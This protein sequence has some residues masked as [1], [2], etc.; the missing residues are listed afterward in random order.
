LGVHYTE[1]GI[2]GEIPDDP[3]KNNTSTSLLNAQVNPT[4]ERYPLLPQIYDDGELHID[5]IKL[6]IDYIRV[7]RIN[8]RV[9]ST[10]AHNW[11]LIGS[12]T[13]HAGSK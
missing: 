12:L 6:A 2:V 1:K 11:R 10:S 3:R 9:L 5:D 4:M 7:N 8:E 13:V